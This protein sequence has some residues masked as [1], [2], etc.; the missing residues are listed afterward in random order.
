MAIT[1]T[2][3]IPLASLSTFRIG[4]VAK[5]VVT[6]ETEADLVE[7]FQTLSD[8]TQYM[9]LGGG[10]NVVFPD[11]DCEMLIIRFAPRGM[12]IEETDQGVFA[13][14]GAGVIWDELVAYT[15]DKELSGLEALSA[16]PG[17]VGATPIQ[18]VGAY[19]CEV[20]DTITTVRAFDVG[21]KEFVSLSNAQCI[22]AYRDSMF[23]HEGRG[24]YIITEVAFRL[25]RTTPLPPQYPGV[26]DFFVQQGIK[27]PTLAQ[28]REAIVAIRAQKLPDP[29]HIAS[30]GSFFKNSIIPKEQADELKLQ[31]PTLAM[32]AVSPTHTKVSTGSLIDLMGW[33][34][35]SFGRIATYK[36]NA[37]VLI[38][39]GGA[40]RADLSRAVAE[41]IDAVRMR[42]GITIE[43]EPELL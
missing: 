11:G 17:C 31:Y 16:I 33:K 24:R 7:L 39:E 6:V 5:E 34:G 8:D 36:N 18:N 42:Y 21:K 9:V 25:S 3:N 22:F 30:V 27:D 14:A 19:G 32:F 23:K 41:I 1:R 12:R 38:N 37:L 4:G 40:T 15:V 29:K 2:Y 13:V 20:K 35:K 28:I 43:P 26:S 10:S